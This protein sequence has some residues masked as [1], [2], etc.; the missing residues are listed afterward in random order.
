MRKTIGNV[1]SVN[2]TTSNRYTVENA[3][4]KT[5]NDSEAVAEEGVGTEID[6]DK[7]SVTAHVTVNYDF[8]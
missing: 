8:K 3:S 5:M 4:A 2:E 6:Y 1:V 7:I